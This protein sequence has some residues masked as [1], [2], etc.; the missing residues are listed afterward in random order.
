MYG[1]KKI[2]HMMRVTKK[3]K[4]AVFDTGYVTDILSAVSR[5]TVI[6]ATAHCALISWYLVTMPCFF[7]LK[8]PVSVLIGSYLHRVDMVLFS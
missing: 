2:T 5:G 7:E 1:E 3:Q 8:S 4:R 6:G